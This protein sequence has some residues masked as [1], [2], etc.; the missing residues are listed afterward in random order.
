MKKKRLFFLRATAVLALALVLTLDAAF[1]LTG[2]R[3]FSPTENRTLQQRP[4]LT[5]QGATSGRF[6]SRF[7]DYISDQF[8]FRDAW[9]TLKTALDRLGGRT[10]SGGVFLGRDGS[11]IQ[12]FV[13]PAEADYAATLA[14]LQ[15]F[16]S[17]HG[18]IPEY[19]MIVPTA[20]S[21][22]RDQLPWPATAGDEDGYLNRLYADLDGLALPIDLRPAFAAA[23]KQVR[24]YYR[25]DHHWTQDGAL[26][27]YRQFCTAA[28]LPGGAGSWEKRLLSADFRGTLSAASGFRTGERDDLYACLPP[29]DLQYV[30]TYGGESARSASMYRA[31]ALDTR[32]QY[33]V[34]LGGNP[35]QVKIET[36]LQNGR[37][38]L[39]LKDSYA[40]CF[41]PLL[42]ADYQKLIV[43]DP[44]Y[45]TGDLEVLMEAEG[46][47]EL[48]ILYNAATL[49]A[50]TALRGDIGKARP[51]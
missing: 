2:S 24:L 44:R 8:P 20:A 46:V 10:E 43:V 33:A 7:D 11:L 28:G 51:A 29:D 17:R 40:N 30:V 16:L 14:A 38:L 13:P 37:T 47:N 45:F 18:D 15:G 23:R 9:V 35:P 31:E 12:D 5:L 50:D 41:A 34:F 1:L 21:V 39:V 3:T 4:A 49:A 25:T 48:L 19:V 26:L 6:E 36:P 32:D 42:A 27:A 22:C